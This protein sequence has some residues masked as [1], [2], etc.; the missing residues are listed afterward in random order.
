MCLT[1]SAVYTARSLGQPDWSGMVKDDTGK[2][3]EK[4]L[5][6]YSQPIYSGL[7]DNKLRAS[8]SQCGTV[9]AVHDSVSA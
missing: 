8:S 6:F 2:V 4:D 7:G 9:L 3:Y 5:G 1:P